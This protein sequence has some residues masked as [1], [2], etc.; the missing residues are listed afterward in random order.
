KKVPEVKNVDVEF[1]WY[2]VWTPDRMSDAAK[3]YFN[4]DTKKD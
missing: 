3:E 1:V 2:P 4:I